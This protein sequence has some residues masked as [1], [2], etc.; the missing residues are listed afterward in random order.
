MAFEYEIRQADSM[1]FVFPITKIGEN[2]VCE[3]KDSEGNHLEMT[4]S[5]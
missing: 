5:V 3:F 2:W 1:K 4:T